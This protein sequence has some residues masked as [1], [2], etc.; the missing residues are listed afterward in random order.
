MPDQPPHLTDRLGADGLPG[1]TINVEQQR[2]TDPRFG[3]GAVWR[4]MGEAD[5]LDQRGEAQAESVVVTNSR[6]VWQLLREM[7]VGLVLYDADFNVVYQNRASELM[8]GFAADVAV[9]RSP[10]GLWI[11][12]D[13]YDS[14]CKSL[15]RMRTERIALHGRGIQ[16]RPDGRVAWVQWYTTPLFDGDDFIGY[17]GT[18]TDISEEL[19][20]HTAVRAAKQQVDLLVDAAVDIA[21]LQLSPAGRVQSW[22]RN[23]ETLFGVPA[24]EA[25]GQDM[26]PLLAQ[27]PFEQARVQ[28]L[29]DGAAGGQRME[30]EGWL[31]RQP[32]GRFWG[33]LLLYPQRDESDAIVAVVLVARDLS[34][35]RQA[36]QKI[37]ESE[38]L[39]SAIVSTTSDAI[40]GLDAQACVVFSNPAAQRIF[41]RSAGLLLGLPLAEVLPHLD[42]P[43]LIG[44]VRTL[45]GKRHDGAT[46]HLE[47]SASETRVNGEVL[48]T[49][50]A[51]DV[52]ERVE[53]EQALLRYREQL[54]ALSR[55]L[56]EAEQQTNRRLAQLLH[57]Q[58]GQTLTTLRISVDALRAQLPPSPTAAIDQS[59]T[60]VSSMIDRGMREVR[61]VL[62]ELR[63]PLLQEHGLGVALDNEIQ[64]E[65]ANHAAVAIRLHIPPAMADRRWSPEVEY[66]VFMVAREAIANALCHSQCRR[67]RVGIE[68]LG[69]QGLRLLVQDDGIGLGPISRALKPGHLGLVGMRER[70]QAIGASLGARSG[71]D[72]RG[73]VIEL[74]Y[75]P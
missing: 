63:P 27:L 69:T 52:T 23:A 43:T 50:T 6:R 66:A 20:A 44:T 31:P 72:E 4:W 34:D 12:H 65:T 14:V 45:S 18:H 19:R 25:L 74:N 62:V 61:Q 36:E 38:A 30:F 53:S 48:F 13:Q 3:Q 51:R 56:M 54:S 58:L 21:M 33:N 46:L 28:Q 55:Q 57:D 5:L 24:L 8:T 29:L 70:S 32:G 75:S 60:R 39:L 2:Q 22:N 11:L 47:A 64:A 16:Q 7:P 41:G 42:L 59:W 67:L 1:V 71:D 35:R 17:L 49:L 15:H 40:L 9:G 10:V 37:R 68:P 73:T 26:R